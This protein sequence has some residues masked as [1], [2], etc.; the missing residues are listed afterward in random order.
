MKQTTDECLKWMRDTVRDIT[1]LLKSR[2][3][4]LGVAVITAGILLNFIAQIY[5]HDYISEGHS[6][7]VL[8]DL[9]LQNLPYLDIDYLYDIF[10]LT[11][12][13][14]FI[15]YLFHKRRLRDVPYVLLLLGIFQCVRAVFIV[16]TPFGNPPMFNGTDGLFNGFSRY[17]LGVYPSGHTGASYLYVLIAQN[18][19]YRR[20]LAFCV[21]VI[22]GSL[23]LSR[24]H[25]S[26]DVLSGIFFAYAIYVFGERNLR[27]LI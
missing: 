5:L 10:S 12:L 18:T 13:I 16:L 25:Y 22:V 6:L 17:E 2:L 11:S 21:L 27:P 3:F 8:S 20:L 7:P 9:I 15:L 1:F 23:F 4:Y 14:L 19:A 26:I 24:G